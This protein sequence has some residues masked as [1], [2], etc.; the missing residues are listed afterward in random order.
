M[1]CTLIAVLIAVDYFSQWTLLELDIKNPSNDVST[2]FEGWC[3][4]RDLNPH[5]IAPEGF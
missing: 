5:G 2:S 3:R 4:R 1:S